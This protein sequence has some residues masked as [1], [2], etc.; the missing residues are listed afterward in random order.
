MR[1]IFAPLAGALLAAGTAWLP[2]Q[3]QELGNSPYSRYGVG[4]MAPRGF[5]RTAGMAG[6]GVSSPSPFQVNELNPALLPYTSFVTF[7]LGVASQYKKIETTSRS[8]K[9]GNVSLRHLGL[10]IPFNRNW[11]TL[12]G[13]KPFS[14]VQYKIVTKTPVVNNPGV[15]ANYFY[16]GEGDISEVFLM[17]GF[18]V[19][20]GL[21]AGAGAS[22]LFGNIVTEAASGLD[23]TEL[24]SLVVL[25]ERK[26][27]SS[28][29]FRG[30]LNYRHKLSDKLYLSAGGTYQ[31]LLDFDAE[32]V[33]RYLG[34]DTIETQS[35][36]SVIVPHPYQVGISLDNGQRWS[37]ALDYAAQGWS[38]FQAFGRTD[39]LL[40]NSRRLSLGGEYTPDPS[41][42]FFKRSTYR[43]G[44]SVGRSPLYFK[45]EQLAERS[46]SLGIT[47]PM[48]YK[49]DKG[50]VYILNLAVVGGMRGTTRNDLI[51]ENFLR[52][53]L[54]LSLTDRWFVRP[55]ID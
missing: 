46:A 48:L 34:A 37:L 47:L 9:D 6:A 8:Q 26:R 14:S 20:K 43:A 21:T 2:L 30:G 19:A 24:G 40:R 17:N 45:G 36:S 25:Q 55:K 16:A 22:Y 54:G 39:T 38:D 12:I 11:T 52:V 4:D 42:T 13:L 29:G 3:A 7:E 31:Y 23:E 5:S 33:V 41:G 15:T 50:T 51:R 32:R 1:K 35:S 44:L 18:R 10:A 28:Y 27:L 53:D 49:P